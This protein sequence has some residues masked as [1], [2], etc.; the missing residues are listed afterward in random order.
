[1][2]IDTPPAVFEKIT[3]RT[4]NFQLCFFRGYLIIDLTKLD[5]RFFFLTS[6]RINCFSVSIAAYQNKISAKHEISKLMSFGLDTK[7]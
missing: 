4:A 2:I 3:T 1:M 5:G 6:K 7:V